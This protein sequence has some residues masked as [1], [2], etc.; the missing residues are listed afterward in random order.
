[1]TEQ[2][3]ADVDAFAAKVRELI[4]RLKDIDMVHGLD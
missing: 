4:A 1:M 3:G 2:A